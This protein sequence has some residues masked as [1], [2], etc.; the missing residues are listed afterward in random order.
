MGA[1]MRQ[2]SMI[3]SGRGSPNGPVR[4]GFLKEVIQEQRSEGQVEVSQAQGVMRAFQA[5]GAECTK[6]QSWE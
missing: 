5:E 6:A 2:H 1:L 3:N 4:E